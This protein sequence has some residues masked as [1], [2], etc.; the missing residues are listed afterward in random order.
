MYFAFSL[1]RGYLA[2]SGG[3]AGITVA[4]VS[5]VATLM[6]SKG[7]DY[8]K[9]SIIQKAVRE[10]MD[11]PSASS[12]CKLWE[13]AENGDTGLDWTADVFD[14]KLVEF[15]REERLYDVLQHLQDNGQPRS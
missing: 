3:P 10:F 12:L 5:S 6:V 9:A 2:V 15:I 11:A 8:A 14:T 4:V 13:W 7:L 1:A